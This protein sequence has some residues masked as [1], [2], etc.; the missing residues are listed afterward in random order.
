MR[1]VQNKTVSHNV[2]ECNMLNQKEYKRRHDNVCRYIRWRLFQK[3]GFETP[4]WYE[5]ES[6][7]SLRMKGT[8]FCG[9]LQSSVKERL[10]LD[11]QILLLLIKPRRRLRS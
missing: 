6:D 10:K 8:R 1:K 9:I 5:H 11:D 4:Q 7:G 3:H 2:S